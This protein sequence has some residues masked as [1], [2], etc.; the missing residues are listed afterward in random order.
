MESFVKYNLQNSSNYEF[1]LLQTKILNPP[2]LHLSEVME[3][4]TSKRLNEMNEF[5]RLF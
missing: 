3:L 2:L 4:K 1:R 5:A